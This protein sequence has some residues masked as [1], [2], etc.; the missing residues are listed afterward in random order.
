MSIDGLTAISYL[1]PFDDFYVAIKHRSHLGVITATAVALTSTNSPIDFT[2]TSAAITFGTHAQS[3]MT[4][5]NVF[6]LWAGN[7]NADTDV[8]YQGASNDTNSIKDDVLAE[9]GNSGASNL[10]SY[11]LY[12]AVDV[13]MDGTI[14]YQGASNDSN[15]IKDIILSHPDNTGASNLFTIFEQL[16]EN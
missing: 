15:S 14:R 2:N 13:N 10:F 12:N 6:A 8:R 4:M 7:A 1:I 9:P 16:P 5:L 11:Q 3:I